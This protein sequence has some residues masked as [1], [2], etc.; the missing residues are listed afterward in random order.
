MFRKT[1]VCT[2]LML[3][4]GSALTVGLTP[5]LAQQTLEK[6]EITGS[7][8]KRIEAE[9]A[10]PVQVITREAIEKTGATTVEQLMQTVTAN[11]SSGTQVAASVSGATTGGISSISLRGLNST[12]TL[13]L[14]NGRRIAPYGLGFTNDR[15]AR[16]RSMAP[17]PSR[18]S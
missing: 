7:S 5:V 9:T 13:V 16:R 10:L 12:R 8:I 15:T 2:G 4:F 18:A 17:T 11:S 14:L 3:A 1:K 6:V